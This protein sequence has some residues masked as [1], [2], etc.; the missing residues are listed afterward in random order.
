MII[1]GFLHFDNNVIRNMIVHMR[2]LFITCVLDCM[3]SCTSDCLYE[4]PQ[5][6]PSS[7]G[8]L[9]EVKTRWTALGDARE[10]RKVW[11]S[12]RRGFIISELGR[13]EWERIVNWFIPFPFL[14]IIFLFFILVALPIS[15]AY[16][17]IHYE[18]QRLAAA[19]QCPVNRFYN[20]QYKLR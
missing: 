9:E 15:L 4:H 17:S 18:D 11:E 19:E 13:V 20:A 8:R 5:S 3:N 10:V 6:D 1:I 16:I 14:A 2:V 7:Q 12:T